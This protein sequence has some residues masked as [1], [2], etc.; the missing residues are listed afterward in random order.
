MSTPSPTA[1]IPGGSVSCAGSSNACV[2]PAADQPAARGLYLGAYGWL[3]EVRPKPR[4]DIM[5]PSC[6]S[7]LAE[8]FKDGPPL[9]V[10]PTNGGHLHAP[11]LNQAVTAA[12]LRA[13]EIANRTPGAPGAFSINLSSERVRKAIALLEGVRTGQRSGALLGYR[14]ERDAA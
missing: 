9:E 5:P 3:E 8:A 1:S 14:F 4:P 2:S 12:I 11:S 10:D 7:A 13:G 6:P